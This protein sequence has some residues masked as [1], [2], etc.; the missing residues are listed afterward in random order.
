MRKLWSVSFIK[1]NI[2][3]KKFVKRGFTLIEIIIVAAL[4][5]I[6][7]CTQI[8]IVSRYMRNFKEE[9]NEAKESFYID[10]AFM[11]IEHQIN[12]AK[13]VGIKENRII[14]KRYD[15]NGYD[16]IRSD[17]DSDIIISYGSI[18]SSNT[19]NILKGTKNFKVE[20]NGKV[21]YITIETKRG[22]VYKR[23]LGLEREEAEKDTY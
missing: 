17:K 14:L 13:S 20:K 19:N 9:I 21:V 6:I 10:E 22:N 3:G 4:V 23:C 15:G 8:I 18:Y 7:T 16:Y 2:K 12:D 5:G 1:E 11:I